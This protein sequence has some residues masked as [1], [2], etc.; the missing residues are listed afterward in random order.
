MYASASLIELTD[1]TKT[2]RMGLV[3]V[4]A[5][6]GVTLRVTPGEWLAVMGPSGSGKS[7]LLHIMGCL[8]SPTSG[9]YRLRGT[10]VSGMSDD[11]LAEVRSREIGFVFQTSNL[12]PR[13][14]ALHQVMLPMQ[15]LRGSQRLG[16]AERRQRAEEALGLVGLR[17]RSRH[18]PAELSG[19]ERQ[20][21]A[22]A[23]ALVNRPSILMADEPTGNLDSV[24]GAEIMAILQRLHDE[25]GVTIVMV[26]HD[27]EIASRAARTIRMRDGRMVEDGR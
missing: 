5:L 8:D 4:E 27:A 11:A 15:Y 17:D 10:E 2:Y 12:L 24:S 13:T 22:I 9:S 19:G 16:P 18:R 21:V 25:H 20:K 14:P 23:R 7:T 3:T 26:T 1:V 6:R